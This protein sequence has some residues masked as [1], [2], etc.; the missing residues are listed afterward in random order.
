MYWS[1]IILI[2]FSTL[3]LANNLDELRL[4]A[5]LNESINPKQSN[6][7]YKELYNKTKLKAYLEE[8]IRQAFLGNLNSEFEI[9]E[10]RKID[11][12]NDLIKKIDIV[13]LIEKKDY[14]NAKKQYF[15]FINKNEDYN[16]ANA[17]SKELFNQGLTKDALEISK[18]YYKK[19]ENPYSLYLYLEML[20]ANKNYKE[21]VKLTEN[22]NKIAEANNK[23]D[24]EQAPFLA[25]RLN[26]LKELGMWDKIVRLD[27]K[28]Y[29]D[30][31][32]KLI[33]EKDFKNV[34][35][36]T[37]NIPNEPDYSLFLLYR[38][39]A[40]YEL[41]NKKYLKEFNTLGLSLY[42]YTKNIDILSSLAQK[43][44]ENNKKDE[45]LKIANLDEDLGLKIYF[46]LKDYKQLSKS[47]M[48]KALK[49]SNNSY[50][51]ES[52]IYEMLDNPFDFDYFKLD[53]LVAKGGVS[54][55]MLNI[56]AYTIIDKKI[57]IN[58]GIKLV[59]KALESEPN[60]AYFLDTLAWGYYLINDCKNAKIIMQKVMQNEEVNKENEVILHNNRINKCKN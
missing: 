56:Y 34:E 51:V 33:K 21:V 58:K 18:K 42:E 44:L 27:P 29:S 31:I 2:C 6:Q 7:A 5:L 35:K 60:N 12:N 47:F 14:K 26:A 41:N 54:A 10:L 59:K 4:E 55:N 15:E 52:Y 46:N 22:I 45:L 49:T 39:N 17:M 57:D 37:R 20:N 16:L 8:A 32:M 13:K 11:S 24:E 19:Y 9:K 23:A 53:E 38:F 50:L 3:L 40:L 36:Y 30:F 25:L 48:Q 28:S 1:K 43:L